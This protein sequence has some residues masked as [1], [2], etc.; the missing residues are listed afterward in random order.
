MPHVLIL[1]YT[2]YPEPKLSIQRKNYG[3][4]KVQYVAKAHYEYFH[5]ERLINTL[6]IRIN[7]DYVDEEEGRKALKKFVKENIDPET[8]FITPDIDG[9][10]RELMDLFTELY[11]PYS[12]AF[13]F[14]CLDSG[15]IA[16]YEIGRWRGVNFQFYCLDSSPTEYRRILTDIAF[17]S[18]V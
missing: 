14:Y 11:P 5:T 1:T 12:D 13:Q 8:G 2:N 17:N 4:K 15:G 16:G 7:L 3:D 6:E 18:I 9:M 10:Y